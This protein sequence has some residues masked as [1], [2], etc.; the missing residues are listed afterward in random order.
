LDRP[1][2]RLLET[3][4]TTLTLS[5]RSHVRL[6]KLARTIADLD[7]VAAIGRPHLAEALQ[8]RMVE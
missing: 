5:A 4:A 2:A 8:F 6:L 1:T 3:A 7:G